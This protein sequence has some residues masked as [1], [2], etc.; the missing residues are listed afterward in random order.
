ML[1][2]NRL[3]HTPTHTF[4]RTHT[5]TCCWFSSGRCSSLRN[6]SISLKRLCD[7]GRSKLCFQHNR[8]SHNASSRAILLL[9]TLGTKSAAR[10]SNRL[11]GTTSAFGSKNWQLPFQILLQ[12]PTLL[13]NMVVSQNR[14][15]PK[16]PI[17]MG[18]FPWNHPFSRI[19]AHE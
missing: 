13:L 19:S 15:T 18:F 11:T 9:A 12:Y 7:L 17:L 2:G 5:H 3:T 10:Y 4:T 6:S 1:L 16:S 14:G 8:T